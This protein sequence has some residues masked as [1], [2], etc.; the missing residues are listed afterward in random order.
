MGFGFRVKG[1]EFRVKGLFLELGEKGAGG[2]G[3]YCFICCP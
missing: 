2:G 1:L 3:G